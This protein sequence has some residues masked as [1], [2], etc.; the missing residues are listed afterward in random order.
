MTENQQ[1]KVGTDERNI[2]RLA[3]VLGLNRVPEELTGWSKNIQLTNGTSVHVTCIA[4]RNQVVPHGIDADVTF[5]LLTTYMQQNKPADGVIEITPVQIC[6]ACGLTPGGPIYQRILDSISRLRSV[7]YRTFNAWSVPNK[8][9]V[10][11]WESNDFGIIDSVNSVG[12][13]TDDQEVLGR[14]QAETKLRIRLNPEIVQ[15]VLSGNIRQLNLGFYGS[16]KKPMSRLLYRTLEELRD[17]HPIRFR[18][19]LTVWAIH[20]GMLDIDDSTPDLEEGVKATMPLRSDKIRRALDPAHA[21][22]M[23]RYLKS[24]EYLGKGIKQQVEYVFYAQEVELVEGVLNSG[25]V[26]QLTERGLGKEQAEKFVKTNAPDQI[27][28]VVKRFDAMIKRGSIGNPGGYLFRL[29]QNPDAIAVEAAPKTNKQ[30]AKRVA[31][32]EPPPPKDPKL[33]LR[34]ALKS[35]LGREPSEATCAAMDTLTPEATQAMFRALMEPKDTAI[36]LVE[37]ILMVEI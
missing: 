35:V 37:A 28:V 12:F 29:L 25:L 18:V 15:S 32:A 22:L 30:Q 26:A 16:L 7:R 17:E 27:E 24:V 4:G 8:R 13:S 19:P 1:S 34:F 3:V 14:F 23:G 10:K 5:A 11:H 9:G 6:R 2:A 31:E 36:A 20:L 21:E 33:G